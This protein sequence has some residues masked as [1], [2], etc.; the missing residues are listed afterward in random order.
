MIDHHGHV[1]NSTDKEPKHYIYRTQAEHEPNFLKVFRSRTTEPLLSKNPEQKNKNLG[2]F[3][4]SVLYVEL[5]SSLPYVQYQQF[6]SKV[7]QPGAIM[8]RTT[9]R[10]RHHPMFALRNI[11]T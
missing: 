8:W 2:F 7:A 3:P 4:I 1:S 6:N 11:Y 5:Y 9:G 10:V